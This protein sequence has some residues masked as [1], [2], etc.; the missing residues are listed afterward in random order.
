MEA[1]GARLTHKRYRFRNQ[2]TLERAEQV[3]GTIEVAVNQIEDL[4]VVSN[5][6]VAALLVQSIYTNSSLFRPSDASR[7]IFS[8]SRASTICK[9]GA[10]HECFLRLASDFPISLPFT[11]ICTRFAIC[12]YHPTVCPEESN[13]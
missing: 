4:A 11:C 9:E 3:G 12:L 2:V 1:D 6:D 7:T 13:E 5:M 8:S 10:N